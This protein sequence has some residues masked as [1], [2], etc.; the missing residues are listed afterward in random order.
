MKDLF[1]ESALLSALGTHDEAT[2]IAWLAAAGP[3]GR[4]AAAKRLRRWLDDGTTWVEEVV[5]REGV[6]R[7][8]VSRTRVVQIA[9]S[10]DTW[11]AAQLAWRLCALEDG[12]WVRPTQAITA[13]R[14]FGG[15]WAE[16]FATAALRDGPVW[17]PVR[18]LVAEGLVAYER[19]PNHL[20]GMLG[21]LNP[22]RGKDVPRARLSDALRA[23]PSLLGREFWDLLA[24]EG[25]TS[26]SLANHDKFDGGETWEDAVVLLAN[27]G[28]IAR[29]QLLD[30][31]LA[32]LS[33]DF[34]AFRASWF[35][36]T[37]D[38]LAPTTDEAAARAG[39]YV[40]LLGSRNGATVSMALRVLDRLE[41]ARRLDAGAFLASAD[42]AL[43]STTKATVTA[44]LKLADRIARRD[45]A[46]RGSVARLAVDA[47]AHAATDVQS[48]ALDVIE[49]HGRPSEGSLRAAIA[50]YAEAVAPSLRARLAAW[51]GESAAAPDVARHASAAPPR[52]DVSPLDPSRA[53]APVATFEAL[54]ALAARSLETYQAGDY[55]VLVDGLARFGPPATET[56]MRLTR[57]LAKRAKD[58]VAAHPRRGCAG[59]IGGTTDVLV[60]AWASRTPWSLEFESHT[61]F[62][63]HR[64][65]AWDRDRLG[66]VPKIPR[67]NPGAPEVF[68]FRPPLLG[69]A[70]ARL[71]TLAEA[72]VAASRDPTAPRRFRLRSTP[73][74]RGGWIDPGVLVQRITEPGDGLRLLDDVHDRVLALLRLA[75][76]RRVEA[77]ARLDAAGRVADESAEFVAALRHTL[78]ATGVAIGRTE[79]VWIAAAR[80]RTPFD[81]DPRIAAAYPA[82]GP[83]AG[84]A[85]R[86]A[87][88]SLPLAP[89]ESRPR[90]FRQFTIDCTPWPPRP[91][92]SAHP[93]VLL[94]ARTDHEWAEGLPP[95]L[96]AHVV[97]WW[98]ANPEPLFASGIET[99]LRSDEK[100]EQVPGWAALL[101]RPDLTPQRLWGGLG[102]ELLAATISAKQPALVQAATD[103]LTDIAAHG[104]D[105]S[106]LPPVRLA[107][108][109]AYVLG[110]E[111]RAVSFTVRVPFRRFATV[112]GSVRTLSSDHA[113]YVAALAVA[114][115]PRLPEHAVRDA[116]PWIEMLREA[117]VTAGGRVADPAARAWLTERRSGKAGAAARALL[118]TG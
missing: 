98:P 36:R 64:A 100:S 112:C 76:Q 38:R 37:H 107:S 99:V 19:Q 24:L 83:D 72:F 25:T 65:G 17:E 47:L 27:D 103:L 66:F 82:G 117:L 50:S 20:L 74:H 34:V 22:W 26:H 105:R 85:A 97:S 84:V 42:A 104:P 118:R 32:S 3:A 108:A 52:G 92:P 89:F 49:R 63:M 96:V 79:A 106:P 81:D 46:H 21:S 4:S 57:P 69:F 70:V 61:D 93:S 6:P 48:L 58:V 59:C 80:A 44:A 51:T 5:T 31:L 23:E 86:H 111:R 13:A 67:A 41:R 114:V 113:A 90:P 77:L 71:R 8:S 12:R 7:G 56:E 62:E 15:D 40:R 1:D 95:D 94:H 29:A 75:P 39:E 30:A 53:V 9:G 18:S 45:T 60:D 102:P 88:P 68:V 116:L 14:A 11:R 91:V 101:D 2:V 109:I 43:H 10:S 78:G 73:T 115:L 28:T 55:E 35:S 110:S 33:A 87:I 54:V 16:R